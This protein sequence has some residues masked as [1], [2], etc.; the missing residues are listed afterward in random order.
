ML[1][2]GMLGPP[3]YVKVKVRHVRSMSGPRAVHELSTRQRG[4]AA[5]LF[6]AQLVDCLKITCC[7]VPNSR[8]DIVAG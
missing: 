3:C 8:A 7:P 5:Q 1:R 6:D 2:L 4:L